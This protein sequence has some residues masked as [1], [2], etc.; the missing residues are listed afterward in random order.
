MSQSQD[1]H[2]R[3]IHKRHL[4][5][6]RFYLTLQSH[7][8]HSKLPPVLGTLL[9]RKRP[10][11]I[12]VILYRFEVVH[13]PVHSSRRLHTLRFEWEDHT[14]HFGPLQP[15]K[16]LFFSHETHALVDHQSTNCDFF[17]SYLS[18]IDQGILLV[19]ECNETRSIMATVAFCCKNKP[20][21]YENQ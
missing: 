19:K 4:L 10:G 11:S 8:P 17:A 18:I 5:D 2:Y 6:D 1:W 3:N 14:N 9:G 12:A 15:N 21:M 7:L 16:I 13:I 20:E